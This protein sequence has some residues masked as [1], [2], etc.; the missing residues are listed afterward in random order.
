MKKL[1]YVI[2]GIV[3]IAGLIP[4]FGFSLPALDCI[5]FGHD[6]NI[7]VVFD[8]WNHPVAC[9]SNGVRLGMGIML[10]A[11]LLVLFAFI[12]RMQ[13]KRSS[14]GEWLIDTYPLSSIMILIGLFALACFIQPA[15][16]GI[17]ILIVSIIVVLVVFVW[18]AGNT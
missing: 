3:Y 15:I 11:S 6:G 14:L 13:E 1:L 7:L 18:V 12:V 10:L 4:A 17:A 8:M 2:A 5:G 16:F 9:F